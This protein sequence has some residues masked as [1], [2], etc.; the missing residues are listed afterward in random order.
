[1]NDK[2]TII[3]AVAHLGNIYGVE[4]K[5]ERMAV[6]AET[7]LERYEVGEILTAAHG[8]V[9]SSRFFPAVADF[10]EAIDGV[11]QSAAGLLEQEAIKAWRHLT[12]TTWDEHPSDFA[13]RI[14]RDVAGT[15]QFN[16]HHQRDLQFIRKDFIRQYIAVSLEQRRTDAQTRRD[17]IAST[18]QDVAGLIGGD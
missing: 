2:Q 18:G 16:D 4:V 11:P 6:Y 7:L 1:M 8:L 17:Q 12:A 5:A 10:V 14:S 3:A 15:T 9:I 13:K